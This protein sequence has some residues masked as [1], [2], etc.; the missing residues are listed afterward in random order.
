ML[1]EA[2]SSA[3]FYNPTEG[4]TP[5][6]QQS[7]NCKRYDKAAGTSTKLVMNFGR[8]V[9]A[10]KATPPQN[11]AQEGL[12]INLAW[13]SNGAHYVGKTAE[14]PTWKN[15]KILKVRKSAEVLKMGAVALSAA[16]A[17]F[18]I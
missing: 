8:R 10:D 6:A 3:A 17:I 9:N 18:S 14:G 7:I 4:S 15:L 12:Q 13:T 1:T 2:S 16:A 11:L 5:V